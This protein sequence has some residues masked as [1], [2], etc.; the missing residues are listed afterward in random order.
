VTPLRIVCMP[1]DVAGCHW[2]MR[3]SAS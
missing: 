1:D 3:R 2:L